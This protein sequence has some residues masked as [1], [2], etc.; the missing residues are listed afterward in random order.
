MGLHASTIYGTTL[1]TKGAL[2]SLFGTLGDTGN[3]VDG[4]QN[5]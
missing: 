5:M 3:N 1:A 2:K 4:H